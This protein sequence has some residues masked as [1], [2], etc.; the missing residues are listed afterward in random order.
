MKIMLSDKARNK[1]LI[2]HHLAPNLLPESRGATTKAIWIQRILGAHPLG[3]SDG[4]TA[5]WKPFGRRRAQNLGHA[6]T[7]K[8][9]SMLAKRSWEPPLARL[10][11]CKFGNRL[12]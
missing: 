5:R 2:L 7:T 6:M 8:A 4:A 11:S 3:A 10:R 1:I 12:I 9:K